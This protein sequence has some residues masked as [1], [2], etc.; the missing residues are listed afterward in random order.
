MLTVISHQGNAN[1]NLMR[2]QLLYFMSIRM[3]TI[4]DMEGVDQDVEKLEPRTWL[5]AI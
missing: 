3:A 5:V 2:H 4:R 1:Q